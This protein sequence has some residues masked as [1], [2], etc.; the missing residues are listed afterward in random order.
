VAWRGVAWRGVAWRGVAWR[1][2]AFP[3]RGRGELTAAVPNPRPRPLLLRRGLELLRDGRMYRL[4]IHADL[5]C[6]LGVESAT[7]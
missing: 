1:G 7:V 6:L 2:V 4:L 5:F 3:E